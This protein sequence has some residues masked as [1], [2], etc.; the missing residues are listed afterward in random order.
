MRVVFDIETYPNC[1]TFSACTPDGVLWWYYEISD[2]R[3]DRQALFQWL[4]DIGPQGELIGFNNVGFDYVVLH[5][6]I[7]SGGK[8]T[9]HDLYLKAKAIIDA[10]DEDRFANM[11]YPSD[12]YV[13]Q[14]DLFKIHHFDNHAR[15]TSLK[16]LEFNMRLANVED[17]PFPVGTLLTRDRAKVLREY[18]FYDV[19]ATRL[20]YLKS[21]PMIQ[22][23]EELTAKH[24]R[25]FMNH[26]DGKIGKDYFIMELEKAG[27]D[28]YEYGLNGRQPKQTKRPTINLNDAILPWLKFENE[29]FQRLIDWLRGQTI[30]QT[31]G[32]FKDLIV[33]TYDVDV[34]FGTGGIHASVENRILYSDDD[35]LLVDVDVEAY[36]PSTAIAQRF[37][38]AH[39]PEVFSDIYADLKRQRQSFKKGTPENAMLKLAINSVFGDSNNKHSVF[40][41]PLMTMQIT[42]NGQLFLCL[43]AERLMTLGDIELCQLNTDGCTFRVKRNLLNQ[44]R[45]IVA[46]WEGL[47]NLKMEEAHYSR[48]FVRD[49]N[50]YCAEKVGGGVK[51][52][53]A[54]AT[55]KEWHQDSSALVVPKVAE[56]VLLEGASI[57]DTV[58]NWPDKFDFFCR[59]KVPRT[60][61]L[62][63][64]GKP[65]PNMCRYYVSKGGVSLIKI[66][67]PL[68]KKP[69]VWR[70]IGVESGWTV[71]PCNDVKDAVLPVN[72]EYYINEIEKL[73]L[74]LKE[75]K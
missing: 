69:D 42:M 11:V 15:S 54:Y 55:K 70:R 56:K 2:W 40:F 16:A 57:R 46:E 35:W 75:R 67:P 52:K 22:F 59:V 28:C 65:L 6:F 58:M 8:A 13:K 53:G 33:H 41:D 36:Y 73:C 30:T 4:V 7:Q 9:A 25:D 19:E 38:P 14:I 45:Q 51:Q 44:F 49:V 31:K 37:R 60:S 18:N 74:P 63:G 29:G 27:I 26:N 12:R 50:S 32:A 5:A 23:R 47:T 48:M 10:Q 71:C 24:N 72:Y 21:I 20:F 62:E 3:N 39:Y 17:L 66:M 61:R 64:D 34:V 68:A 1:F 43:L